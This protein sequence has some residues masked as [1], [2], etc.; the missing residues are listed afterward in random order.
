MIETLTE[1]QKQAVNRAIKLFRNL[2]LPASIDLKGSVEAYAKPA[3]GGIEWG[4]NDTSGGWP[5]VSIARGVISEV[6]S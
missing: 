2:G 1:E 6:S 3:D 4:L 5:G